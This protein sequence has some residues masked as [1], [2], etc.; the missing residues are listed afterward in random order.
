MTYI[1]GISAFYH[2][3]AAAL[4]ADGEI[5]AAAQEER[6]T[7]I[8][9]N[10]SFPKNAVEYC[11]SEANI[12]ADQ[13]DY[14]AFYDK[15]L[16]KFERLIETYFAFAPA[17]FCSFVKAM[18][19]W[20]RKKLHIPRMIDKGLGQ[21]FKGRYI[22][23]SHHES[24][25]ASAFYPSPFQNSAIL[26]ID[27]VGEW[28][29]ASWGVGQDNK[30]NLKQA[31]NF[32]HSLG[33]LYSAFT[34]F[35]GFRV[36]S[37]E[38]K[39]MGLA[40][41][42]NPIYKDRIIENLLDL[43][44]DGSF[45]LH[46]KYF[47]YC[48]GSTMTSAKFAELFDGP[49]RKAESKITQRE[50]DLAASIQAVTEEI[51]LRIARYIKLKT[52][53]DYLTIAGGVG[54]NCV[55][56]GKILQE[57][58]FKDIW[59]QPAAGDAGG[60]LG[61]A[62]FAWHQLLENSRY[63]NGVD[64]SQKGSLLGPAFN[65]EEIQNFL[66]SV[67]AKYEKFE[68]YNDINSKIAKLLADQKVIG[69]FA[70][71]MEFGPRA[72]GN[73]SIIGDPRSAKMQSIMNQKIK[74]RE[75]FRPFAP[76]VLAEHASDWFD[77]PED[78]KSPYMLLVTQVS[79]DHLKK[80][81]KPKSNQSNNS[82]NLIETLLSNQRSDIPAIT[83]VDNSAR[84]QTV[85][86]KTNPRYHDL[87]QKFYDLTDCPVIIN[88]SFNVRGEPIVATPL[89]AWNCFCATNMDALVLGNFLILKKNQPE[90]SKVIQQEHLSKFKLD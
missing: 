22:F 79:S 57:N 51:I 24:H 28:N 68:N 10:S 19:V 42:G 78:K 23:T 69:N 34:F 67:D 72:L 45:K 56:N 44:Q 1:L 55:A 80:T 26:T 30:I 77:L 71:K 40:P 18:P 31:L 90:I 11:L 87:I 13:I 64:D 85:D 89:D 41:Y 14:I 7:R 50:M 2:D 5:I 20:M 70:G 3:S 60:A 39:L 36:N 43:K 53:S 48:V 38:Y 16:R 9:H 74:F 52:N 4:I 6:F 76:S 33:L 83:H 88:T 46:M 15:P 32:P 29:T 82:E 75:S 59:V 21:K 81:T 37:G 35:T 25:A 47:N 62:L 8:K 66:D 65:E 49:P 58:I 17:G 84:V 61:C 63:T 54:L 86:S 27:G 12:T 73:R